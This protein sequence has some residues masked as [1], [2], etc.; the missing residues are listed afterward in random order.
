MNATLN[1]SRSSSLFKSKNTIVSLVTKVGQIA[2]AHVLTAVANA[3]DEVGDKAK[4]ASFVDYG[5]RDALS[6]ADIV[7]ITV[8]KIKN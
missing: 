3:I 8:I 4:D 1:L 5:T 6:Y 7:V 2:N